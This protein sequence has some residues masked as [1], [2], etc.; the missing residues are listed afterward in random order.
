MNGQL[1][2]YRRSLCLFLVRNP[3]PGLESTVTVQLEPRAQTRSGW[4]TAGPP[5]ATIKGEVLVCVYSSFMN[6]PNYYWFLNLIDT[7]PCLVWCLFIVHL[8]KQ[9]AVQ[10][11]TFVFRGRN[12]SNVN[13]SSVRQSTYSNQ[14]PSLSLN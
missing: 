14:S 4:R 9:Q 10:Y 1:T 5:N 12:Q 13:N 11:I 2:D 8:H 3:Q 6:K 7:V